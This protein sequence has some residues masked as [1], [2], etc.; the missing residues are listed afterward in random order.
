MCV[1]D[2]KLNVNKSFKTEFMVKSKDGRQR[3]AIQES[4]GSII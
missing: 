3:I 1:G 4:K 2:L